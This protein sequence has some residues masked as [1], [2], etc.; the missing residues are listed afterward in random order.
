MVDD[1]A[2]GAVTEAEAELFA[3]IAALPSEG[4]KD[5][6]AFYEAE[7]KRPGDEV[8]DGAL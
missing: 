8:F 7:Y 6:R 3:A 2:Y 5:E 1:S 4:E